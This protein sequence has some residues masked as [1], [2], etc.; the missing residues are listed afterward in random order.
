MPRSPIPT[1]TGLTTKKSKGQKPGCVTWDS[2]PEQHRSNHHDKQFSDPFKL[3]IEMQHSFG[4]YRW[5]FDRICRQLVRALSRSDAQSFAA[6][7]P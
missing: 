5:R 1:D 3:F 6:I 4:H 7:K 2:D